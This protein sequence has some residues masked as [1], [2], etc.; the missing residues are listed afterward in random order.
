MALPPVVT[1]VPNQ[2]IEVN[3][4][5][6]K[7]PNPT[8]TTK[9]LTNFPILDS[10]IGEKEKLL[11][12]IQKLK[13]I[14]EKCEW[15]LNTLRFK[16]VEEH[17]SELQNWETSSRPSKEI[18]NVQV[19]L[20][21]ELYNFT[22]FHCVKFRR[23]EVV[24][25]FTSMNEHQERVSYG[26]QIFIRNKKGYLGKWVMPMSINLNNMLT[27]IP[28]DKLE[29]VTP[30]LKSC[31]HEIDCYIVRQKQFLSL[32]VYLCYENP[33]KIIFKLFKIY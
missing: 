13:S 18:P 20:Q 28:I 14:I 3:E 10:T 21:N 19:D 6:V 2:L 4:L 31:K 26:V 7:Y 32:K 12:D 22:G 17:L 16:D 27:K 1:Q 15:Q 29:N 11:K 8:Q 24:F 25:N 5:S 30:F 9:R 33:Y 23:D